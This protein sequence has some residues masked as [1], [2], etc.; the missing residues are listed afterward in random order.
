MN[1]FDPLHQNNVAWWGM[2]WF[3]TTTLSAILPSTDQWYTVYRH[4]SILCIKTSITEGELLNGSGKLLNHVTRELLTVFM[5]ILPACST[6]YFLTFSDIR[7]V[8]L[9]SHSSY[10]SITSELTTFYC[11]SKLQEYVLLKFFRSPAHQL[12][13]SVCYTATKSKNVLWCSV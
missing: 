7:W 5:P 2:S 3:L 13:F 1:L 10:G 11:H 12:F 8:S 9:K 4:L 6:D